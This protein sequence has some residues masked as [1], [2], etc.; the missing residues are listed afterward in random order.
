VYLSPA[1]HPPRC[2]SLSAKGAEAARAMTALA[3]KLVGAK[4]V[5][6]APD[7]PRHVFLL[8]TGVRWARG[9]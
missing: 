2:G 9:R 4:S 3:A 1:D 5:Y 8:I 7:E 6:R